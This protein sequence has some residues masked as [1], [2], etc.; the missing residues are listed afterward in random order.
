MRHIITFILT[1]LALCSTATATTYDCMGSGLAGETPQHAG[2]QFGV[3]AGDWENAQ[4]YVGRD[5]ATGRVVG[6]SW[7]WYC[8]KTIQ[9]PVPPLVAVGGATTTPSPTQYT[10]QKIVY[11]QNWGGT[12]GFWAGMQDKN[13]MAQMRAQGPAWLALVLPKQC[14]ELE[15]LRLYPTADDKTL[16][17]GLLSK[18]RAFAPSP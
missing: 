10:T 14:H 3:R 5:P 13:M 6:W 12:N 16:C 1:M 7:Y 2:R 11:V 17:E 9:V 18:A 8:A 15:A 4:L